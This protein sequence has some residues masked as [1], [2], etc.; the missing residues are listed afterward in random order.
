MV[1]YILIFTVVAIFLRYLLHWKGMDLTEIY[2]NKPI[3]F[4]HRGDRNNF[5]ENTIASFRSTI[6]CGLNAVE[7]DVMLT[8]DDRLICSHNFDLG[9]QTNGTGFVDDTT[10]HDL[11]KIKTGKK[12]DKTKQQPIPLLTEAINSLP[13]NVL[14]NIEI[15]TKKIFDFEAAKLVVRLIKAN[16]IPQKIIISSFNPLVVRFVK[17]MSKSTPT[18]Y[19][20]EERKYFKGVYIARPDCLN[21]DIELLADKYFHF[22]KRRNM[23]INVWAVNSVADRNL[24]ID[25][26]VDGIITDNPQLAQN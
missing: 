24:L 1:Y 9:K 15:K 13:E 26:N 22:C 12:F 7:L 2:Q 8:K 3:Y 19:I 6:E 16:K 11:T 20:F 5:P 14:I 4:G 23:R 25:K 10:Y 21:P 18:G 17:I